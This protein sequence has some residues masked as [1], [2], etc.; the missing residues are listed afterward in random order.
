[1]R[2]FTDTMLVLLASAA[3]SVGCSAAMETDELMAQEDVTAEASQELNSSCATVTPSIT[4]SGTFDYVT[5]TGY[6][7][8]DR[9]FVVDHS[10]YAEA[11]SS[12]YIEQTF[13]R[14]TDNYGAYNQTDCG[15]RRMDVRL[16]ERTSS[17]NVLKKN[18]TSLRGT[19]ISGGGLAFCDGPYLD[20][21]PDMVAGKNYRIVVSAYPSNATSSTKKVEIAHLIGQFF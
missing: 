2:K 1:M 10:G 14:W 8:C 7:K 6:N 9:G 16:Y 19:W 21:D 4:R 3:M 11:P 13:A 12:G 5:G 18:S 15:R 20:L 17:G